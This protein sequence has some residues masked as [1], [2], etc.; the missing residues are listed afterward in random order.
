M[1]EHAV[2]WRDP[3]ESSHLYAGGLAVADDI[4]Q[5][6]G[7]DGTFPVVK[8]VPCEEIEAISPVSG[9]E[10]IAEFP[11]FRIDLRNGSSIVLAAAAGGG[12]LYEIV[13]A[14]LNLLG[15]M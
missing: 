14:L 11:S 7:S 5:L 15:N 4:V 12:A 1:Q 2:F 8:H 3:A 6:R 9:E 13:N 10:P